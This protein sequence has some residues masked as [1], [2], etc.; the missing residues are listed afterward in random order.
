[1]NIECPKCFAEFDVDSSEFKRV[2]DDYDT[3]CAACEHEF[4]IGLHVDLEVRDSRLDT[5]ELISGTYD[6]LN[7]LS[8]RGE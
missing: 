8:V 5:P 3:E 1:M 2:I 7:K 6:A 4:S